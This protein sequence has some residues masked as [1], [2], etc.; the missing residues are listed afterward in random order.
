MNS[1]QRQGN[2]ARVHGNCRGYSLIEVMVAV[3]ILS[4]VSVLSFI[5]LR[6]SN[7]AVSLATAKSEVQ[8]NLRDVMAAISREVEAAFIPEH[9][10]LT[11]E[12]LNAEDI[13]VLSDGREIRFWKVEQSPNSL[14]PIEVGPLRIFLESED[15]GESGG[16]AMNAKLDAGEDENGDGALTRR[17]VLERDD[18]ERTLAAANDVA[19]LQ[20]AL[21]P[22]T[23]ENDERLT[24]LQVTLTASRRHGFN[25]EHLVT[26]TLTSV[27]QMSNY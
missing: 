11:P 4:V 22:S 7:E 26:A 14:L 3:G 13:E 21:L 16:N 18:T 8:G 5:V 6:S 24:R 15:L 1:A 25:D 17:V 9:V 19:D 23:N 12:R 27:I 10:S 2:S 20:F